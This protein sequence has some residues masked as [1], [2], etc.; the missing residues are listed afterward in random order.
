MLGREKL[1]L[2]YLQGKKRKKLA[3]IHRVFLETKGE[4]EN[5]VLFYQ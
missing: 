2:P 4:K 5:D 1:E 3:V